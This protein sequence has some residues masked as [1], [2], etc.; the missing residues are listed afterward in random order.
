MR[1]KG[2]PMR[3][4]VYE[5]FT[6]GGQR[7][8]MVPRD[9]LA[10]GRA[11]V[12]ALAGDLARIPGVT[13]TL[14]WHFQLAPPGL[15]VELLRTGPEEVEERFWERALACCHAVWPIAPE[16]QGVLEEVSRTVLDHG[17]RLLGST[18]EAVRV[19]GSKGATAA[20]LAQAGVP[21]APTRA[22]T[23]PLP[24]SQ[25]GWVL[26][27][28]RGE[29]G[30]GV[31]FLPSRPAL[32]RACERLDQHRHW[33]VQPFLPGRSCSLSLLV[34]AAEARVIS[35]NYQQVVFRPREAHLE[36]V[37]PEPGSARLEGFSPLL[38]AL[39][40]AVPGLWGYVGVDFIDTASG[41]VVIEVNPRLTTAYAGLDRCQVG[42]PAAE[43]LKAAERE[44]AVSPATWDKVSHDG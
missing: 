11:M 8:E 29:G 36:A 22:I 6:G 41:P 23:D 17:G 35:R 19:A 39:T 37:T 2:K 25:A 42:N 16:S 33:I 38:E 1:S 10:E 5:Y 40:Q 26:K 32:R 13:V 21:V 12:A 15:P 43:V 24:D 18:P 3:V 28:D 44:A 31:Q 7:L 34:D 27:P 30:A 4:L 9:L 14:A 20:A